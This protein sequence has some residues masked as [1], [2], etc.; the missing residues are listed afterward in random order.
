MYVPA[1]KYSKKIKIKKQVPFPLNFLQ[2]QR[3]FVNIKKK[4]TIY[5]MIY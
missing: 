1:D 5:F 4:I 2:N 3:N